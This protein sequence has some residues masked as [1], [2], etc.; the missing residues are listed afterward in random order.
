MKE[1][2]FKSLIGSNLQEFFYNISNL[3]DGLNLQESFIRPSVNLTITFIMLFP[4][5]YFLLL[6]AL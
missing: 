6:T 4:S 2:K 3:I 5:L 1:M